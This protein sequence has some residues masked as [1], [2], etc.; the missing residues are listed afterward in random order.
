MGFGLTALFVW[1]NPGGEAMRTG[2]D[3]RRKPVRE[4]AVCQVRI[5]PGQESPGD[6]CPS[7]GAPLELS[8]LY[9]EPYED[10]PVDKVMAHPGR[11]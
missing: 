10:C 4:C 5:R 2:R 1:P 9:R 3:L 6:V 8:R 7:C 11:R